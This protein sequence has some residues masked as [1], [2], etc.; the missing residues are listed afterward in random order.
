[1]LPYSYD[2]GVIILAEPYTPSN[3]VYGVLPPQRILDN[4]IGRD[5]RHFVTVGYGSE[6]LPPWERGPGQ[7]YNANVR[8]LEVNSYISGSEGAN[9][10]FSNNPGI[11][12]G[13]CHG[14]SGGPTFYKDSKLIVG[15]I[16]KTVENYIST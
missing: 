4:L 8:L 2:V 7:R 15:V 9:A 12:G 10:K 11:G 13:V 5:K 16:K 3:G 1:L 14:D 6:N